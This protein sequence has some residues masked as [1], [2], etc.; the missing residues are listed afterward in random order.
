MEKIR[1]LLA[2]IAGV[3]ILGGLG[4]AAAGPAAASSGP[5][6]DAH[7][8]G[9]AHPQVRPTFITVGNGCAPQEHHLQWSHWGKYTA[10]GT[11]DDVLI[12]PACS[13]HSGSLYLGRPRSHNGRKWF[14]RMT[15]RNG[16][17]TLRFHLNSRGYWDQVTAHT[18]ALASAGPSPQSSPATGPR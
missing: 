10:F 14:T 4:L 2:V 12:S 3:A 13:P 15:M 1:R 6:V 5:Y 11:S 7:A 17:A 18:T 16:S 9:W 8:T